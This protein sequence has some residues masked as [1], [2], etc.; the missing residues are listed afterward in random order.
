MIEI[1]SVLQEV[2]KVLNGLV[3]VLAALL[4]LLSAIFVAKPEAP[5]AVVRFMFRKR[6]PPNPA[7]KRTWIRLIAAGA[8]VIL[9]IAIAVVAIM[10]QIPPTRGQL[11]TRAWRANDKENW[12]RVVELTTK[13][14]AQFERSAEKDQER[15]INEKAPA[16]KPGI[17]GANLSEEDAR[18]NFS[19]GLINDVATA[20]Y[21]RGEANSQLGK[22]PDARADWEKVLTYPYALTWDERTNE[23]WLTKDGAENKLYQFD[24]KK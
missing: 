9:S 21:L 5:I 4:S 22:R 3:G 19:R 20:L 8:L 6:P 12:G 2:L 11:L 1:L 17:V 15:L 23:F 13:L 18:L 10:P 7:Q 24:E 16:A 14:L